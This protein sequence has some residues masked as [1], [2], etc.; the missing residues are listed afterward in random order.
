M[1]SQDLHEAQ[2]TPSADYADETFRS[3]RWLQYFQDNKRARA[4]MSF[5]S[6][7]DVGAALRAP[8]IRS[9]QRFQ[10]GETGEGLH[11]KRYARK[12]RDPVYE[13]CIDMFVKEEQFHARVLADM[14]AALDGTLLTWHWSD[15][16]FILLRRMLGLKTEIF[17]LLVA[18]VI[19]K[20]FYRLCA[21]NLSN[22]RLSDAFSLIVL[23][24]IGHLEFHCAFLRSRLSEV[25]TPLRYAIYYAW[26]LIFYAGCFVFIA[27]HRKTLL[28]LDGSP[29]KFLRQCSNT[30]HRAAARALAVGED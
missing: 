9:L 10:I 29:R 15:L 11:L 18:E 2:E 5:S 19:G 1:I 23:D 21:D 22:D 8:L 4:N 27:D 12:T 25:S 30:F 3:S 16:V 26:T 6:G 13:Q 20:C 7:L 24:E 17:I 14:I 28:A